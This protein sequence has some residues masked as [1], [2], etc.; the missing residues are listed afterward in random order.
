MTSYKQFSYTS[1]PDGEFFRYFVLGPGR[2]HEQLT[3]DLCVSRLS[4]AP[5]YEAISYVWGDPE[6][7]DTVLCGDR[8]IPITANLRDAL[9]RVRL[10]DASRF[11]WADSICIDQSNQRERGHQVLFM[12]K[13]YSGARQVLICLGPDPDENAEDVRTLVA[14]VWAM[15]HDRFKH[16]LRNMEDFPRLAVSDPLY[17]DSRWRSFKRLFDLPWF[18]RGWVV[19]EAALAR[20]ASALWGSATID[21]TQ[22]LG[23]FD[24]LMFQGGKLA[25]QS[26][27]L[28][29]PNAAL[30]QSYRQRR[31]AVTK[32]ISP[33]DCP[34]MGI[35]SLLD[36]ARVLRLKDPR[37]RLY[38][39]LT[40]S[41]Q[42]TGTR[43]DLVPDY[44]KPFLAVYRDFARNRLAVH[45]ELDLL[46]LVQHTKVSLASTYPSWVPRWDIHLLVYNVWSTSQLDAE[47]T[48]SRAG[49]LY[50]PIFLSE[51]LLQVRGVVIDK[52]CCFFTS[53]W[54]TELDWSLLTLADIWRNLSNTQVDWV[55]PKELLPYALFNALMV[56]RNPAADP[57]SWKSLQ[58]AYLRTLST[59]GTKIDED[60]FRDHDDL[61]GLHGYIRDLSTARKFVGTGRGYFGMVPQETPRG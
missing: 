11:L 21:W 46:N 34:Q 2:D 52:G 41:E 58:D 15:I 13:I 45:S 20:S 28:H 24:W 48:S 32:G 10:P 47:K 54:M 56:G 42:L 40:L 22:V 44:E 50:D 16:I 1:L 38:A 27:D 57:A 23:A 14:D 3:V 9:R 26:L 8:A 33:R 4:E 25:V 36:Y 5:E 18:N 43:L 12:G 59:D 19:Q 6:M 37:D 7:A 17:I 61:Q 30:R 31:R 29:P 35:Y 51:S 60:I 39:F 49:K 55:Y 53:E